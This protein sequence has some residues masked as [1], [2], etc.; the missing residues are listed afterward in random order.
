MPN[1]PVAVVH[2]REITTKQYQATALSPAEH[3]NQVDMLRAQMAQ[4]DPADENTAIIRQIFDQQIQSLEASVATLPEQVLDLM[5]EN[6]LVRQE[7]ERRGI[8]VSAEELEES[9]QEWFGYDANPDPTPTVAPTTEAEATPEVTQA[10]RVRPPLS[11]GDRGHGG[12]YRESHR[13]A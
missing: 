4:L 1:Q 13:R 2:G 12:S 3:L 11:R 9:V 10:P 7:A 8:T 6:E 5:I